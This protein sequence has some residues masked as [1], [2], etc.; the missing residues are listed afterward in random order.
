MTSFPKFYYFTNHCLHCKVGISLCSKLL[1]LTKW[2]NWRVFII[3]DEITEH[4]VDDVTA[5]DGTLFRTVYC[6]AK[7]DI[8]SSKIN[9]F[10]T[11]QRLNGLKVEYKNLSHDTTSEIQD[12]IVKLLDKELLNRMKKS[13]VFG[14]T[15]DEST[16]ISVEKKLVLCVKYLEEVLRILPNI[17]LYHDTF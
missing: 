7:E 9:S 17:D 12:C 11:L 15:L 5:E 2:L 10:L 4:V 1:L 13:P 16:D 3:S 6:L 14:I 8:P